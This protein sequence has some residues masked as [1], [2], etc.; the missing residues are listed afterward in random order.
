MGVSSIWLANDLRN[1]TAHM[2]GL[3]LAYQ[4]K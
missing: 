1:Y 4:F 3:T 2:M